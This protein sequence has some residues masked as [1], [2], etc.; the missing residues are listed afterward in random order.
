MPARVRADQV[1]SLYAR[2]HLTSASMGFGAVILCGVMWQEVP[3]RVLTAWVALIVAN[4]LWRGALVRAWRKAQPGAAAAVRWGRYWAIGSTIAG[5]LWGV[6]G[7]AMFPASPAYQGLLM[8]CLFGVVL[9]AL[10][11]TADYKPS[12]YGFVLAALVPPIVRV[13]LVGDAP[14]AF[15]AGVMLIVMIGILAF[16]H[17]LND[18]LTEALA[19]RYQNS[20]LIDELKARTRAAM[21]ARA[22]AEA[23]NRG[24]SQ[25]LAAASHDL[26]QPLHALS[27]YV[28]ALGVRARDAEWQPLVGNVQKAIDALETQFGQLLDLSRLD[29]GAL[30]LSR[31]AFPLGALLAEIAETFGAQASARGLV[32]RVVQTRL[33]VDSD[34]ELL[35]RIVR[36]LVANALNYTREGG[37]VVGVRLR[38]SRVA[39]EVVDTGVG[40]A[41]EHRERIFDD[42]YQIA[43]RA[44]RPSRQSGM[45]LGLAIVRRFAQL[46]G[47][48]VT[49]AS[50]LGR[51]SRF[52]IVVPRA[53]G[54]ADSSRRVRTLRRRAPERPPATLRGRIV[55]VIDDDPAAIEA[56]RSLFCAWGAAV[57]DGADAQALLARLGDLERYPDMLVVDYRLAAGASGVDAVLTLRDELGAP[58]PALIVSGDTGR[59]AATLAREAGL[60]ILAKPVIPG[61]LEGACLALLK[62]GAASRAA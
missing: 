41:P 18:I 57:A 47:H 23:A 28:G 10:N 54:A 2:W 60:A 11:L 48:D 26:R 38:G 17:R 6:A 22:A 43:E 16:G 1:A 12:F 50:V 53:M 59:E 3:L 39:I 36:N 31:R 40:I 56:M 15:L 46:L 4:Q 8:V 24:K 62:P 19:T 61:A 58:I 21:D 34:P 7:S 13:G 37:V 33:W 42:F 52:S 51:G 49:V 25:L 35:A 30:V 14:H 20:E 45:G 32:L 55:G 29:A 27:L 9:G 44:E 5:A